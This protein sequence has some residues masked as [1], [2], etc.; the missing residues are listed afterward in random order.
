M[1]LRLRRDEEEGSDFIQRPLIA[2]KRQ[3]IDA[4]GV[5]AEDEKFMGWLQVS[6]RKSKA[7]SYGSRASGKH[8]ASLAPYYPIHIIAI[9]IAARLGSYRDRC[10]GAL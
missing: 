1:Q 9:M 2:T 7:N 8:T 5:R 6:P 4:G 3:D 10:M